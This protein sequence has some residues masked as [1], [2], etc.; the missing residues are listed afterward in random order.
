M[1]LGIP[2]RI[3][4]IDDAEA[5]LATVEVAGVRRQ[6]NIVCVVD[7]EHP[8]ESCVGD[9]VLLHV[10][11]AMSRIDEAEAAETLR[12]LSQLGEMQAELEAMQP[13]DRD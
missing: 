9:W 7:D 1:C 12:I 6:V 8:L 11:F 13:T 10:G 5:M 3:V 2:A 4:R